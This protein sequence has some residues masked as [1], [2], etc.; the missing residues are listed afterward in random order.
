MFRPLMFAAMIRFKCISLLLVLY[1]FPCFVLPLPSFSVILW[2]KCCYDTI[3]FL[4][5]AY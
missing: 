1:L 2:I 5:L 3:L 4:L